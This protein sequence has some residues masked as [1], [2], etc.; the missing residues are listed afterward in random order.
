MNVSIKFEKDRFDVF[1]SEKK[2][3]QK[4]VMQ[5][6][7]ISKV[8]NVQVLGFC[9]WNVV[10]KFLRILWKK[11]V[12]FF[13]SFFIKI[14]VRKLVIVKLMNVQE[15]YWSQLFCLGWVEFVKECLILCWIIQKLFVFSKVVKS[16]IRK[17]III[18]IVC[19]LMMVLV[20][21]V[22]GM[23]F[24]WYSMVVWVVF[25][26]CGMVRFIIYLI[27]RVWQ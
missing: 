27:I 20:E 25:L 10:M 26:V 7:Q 13:C 15:M 8:C 11:L 5:F 17:S 19:L 1:L 2:V 3:R 12:I 18:F 23:L 9:D 24:E 16:V 14:I 21:V 4:Y 22:K 6:F